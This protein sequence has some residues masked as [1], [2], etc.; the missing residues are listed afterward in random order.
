M[1]AIFMFAQSKSASVLFECASTVSQLSSSAKSA[2]IAYK[3]YMNLLQ[4]QNDNNVRSIVINRIINLKSKHLKLLEENIVE[5]LSIVQESTTH[6]IWRKALELATDLISSRSWDE[7]I[8]FLL[9]EI[10]NEAKAE[11]SEKI[12]ITNEYW[13]F[14]ISRISIITQEYPESIPKVMKTLIE[15]FITMKE[16]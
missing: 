4:D 16:N 7:V 10:W 5:I 1:N 8:K 2:Q 12:E 3:C 11:V 13:A 9:T 6:D 14:I 15:N